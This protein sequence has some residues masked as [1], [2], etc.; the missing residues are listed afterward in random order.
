M[1]NYKRYSNE[2]CHMSYFYRLKDTLK[3]SCKFVQY[4]LTNSLI[5]DL[6]KSEQTSL[7]ATSDERQLILHKLSIIMQDM[8]TK[9]IT[10][11]AYTINNM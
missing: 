9:F 11:N 7:N 5:R 8:V 10:H 1:H 2:N 6:V 4:F 3:I